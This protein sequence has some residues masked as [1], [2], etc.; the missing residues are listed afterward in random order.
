MV[1]TH[2]SQ[3]ERDTIAVLRSEGHSLRSI[4]KKMKRDHGT[5]SRE[6]KRNAP[7]VHT[8]YYLPHKAHER[9]V[10]RNSDR[11]KRERL[12]DPRLRSYVRRRIKADWSPELTAGRWNTLHPESSISYEAIYQW[13]YADARDLIPY[14]VRAHKKRERRGY[15]R[16]HKKS[17]IPNRISISERPRAV[18]KRRVVGHWETDTAVSRKSKAALQVTAER[19][20]RYTRIAKLSAKTAHCMRVGLT[21]R[22]SRVPQRLRASIT[23]DNGTENTDHEET[24]RIL[25]TRS[26]FCE[27]YHSWE[28]GTVENTIGLVRR[29]LPKKTDFAIIS[30]KDI[31]KIERW[32]NNRPR[33]CLNFK[34]PAEAM[35]IERVA[36]TG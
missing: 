22:L 19:K 1:Y 6:L 16:K 13:I 34:T 24:N 30:S 20:T 29:F 8:G 33:K 35:K 36:L 27:P 3:D 9:A 12:K 26:Y 28:K 11:A 31:R 5:L 17:H 32:I 4:A 25:G 7:P 10:K 18:E 21:R 2:L 23:Y 15:S 14:L